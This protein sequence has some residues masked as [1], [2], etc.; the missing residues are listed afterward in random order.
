[1]DINKL[2]E[3]FNLDLQTTLIIFIVVYLGKELIRIWSERKITKNRIDTEVKYKYNEKLIDKKIPIYTEHFSHLKNSIGYY[4]HIIDNTSYLENFIDEI[5]NNLE[6]EKFFKLQDKQKAY[7]EVM[8]Y[9]FCINLAYY[10]DQ[11]K[12]EA[13]RSANIFSLNQIY[14]NDELV[15]EFKKIDLKIKEKI[16]VLNIIVNEMQ[17]EHKSTEF[18]FR[19]K[20]IELFNKNKDTD[21]I[22][23]I[24]SYLDK[25]KVSFYNEFDVD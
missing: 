2:I 18:A 19:K 20:Y 24:E 23:F 22:S 15:I 10:I 1:M 5:Y 17:Q 13:I 25:I 11:F 7:K 9:R 14:V 8:G 6:H 3:K 21:F 16:N 12:I 4:I